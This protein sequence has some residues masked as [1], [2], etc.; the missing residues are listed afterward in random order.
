MKIGIVGYQG[1]GKSTLFQWLTGEK[2]PDP[3][4]WL[5]KTKSAMCRGARTARRGTLPIYHPKKVTL[6]AWR[7]WTRRA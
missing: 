3:V 7:S 6:A 1:S 4:R 5:H 2:P